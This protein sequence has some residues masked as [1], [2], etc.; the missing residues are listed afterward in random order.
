MENHRQC[1]SRHFGHSSNAEPSS[2]HEIAIFDKSCEAI[3]QESPETKKPKKTKAKSSTTIP[4][5]LQLSQEDKKLLRRIPREFSSSIWRIICNHHR[6]GGHW[7]RLRLKADPSAAIL[8]EHLCRFCNQIPSPQ[9][10][11]YCIVNTYA[12]KTKEPAYSTTLIGH[13]CP[14]EHGD[15]FL[16]TKT[17]GP[18]A[19]NSSLT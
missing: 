2:R 17:A 1:L 14:Q 12:F 19:A 15:F 7:H 5:H 16:C 8:E 3:G 11:F 6:L 10:I 4:D 9:S 18:K 13:T